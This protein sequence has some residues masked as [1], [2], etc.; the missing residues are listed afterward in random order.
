MEL[1]GQWADTLLSFE[2]LFYLK[3]AVWGVMSLLAGSGLLAAVH[4]R[5][6]GSPV[7][8]GFGLAMLLWG[9]LEVAVALVRRNGI[10]MRDLTAAITLDRSLWFTTGLMI[11]LWVASALAAALAWHFGRRLGVVGV[12]VATTAHALAVAVL[13]L[14][15]IP[16]IVR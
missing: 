3:L 9:V 5:R 4:M 8:S 11:G 1:T 7:L 12:G 6:D 16:A 15:L 2:R 10:V 14:Q 13:V